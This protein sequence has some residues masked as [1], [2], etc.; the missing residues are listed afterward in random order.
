VVLI[1]DVDDTPSVLAAT[2]LLTIDHN[3]LLGTNDSKRNKT[4]FTSLAGFIF[5][6]HDIGQHTLIWPFRTRSSSSNSSL[7]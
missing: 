7:S 2:D 1:F 6:T 3:R 5:A 4:L